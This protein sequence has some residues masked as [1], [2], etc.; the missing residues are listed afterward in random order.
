MIAAVAAKEGDII[1][2]VIV[3]CFVSWN[4]FFFLLLYSQLSRVVIVFVCKEG[5]NEKCEK[6][7]EEKKNE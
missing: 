6:M 2:H 1:I 4:F 7:R 5:N 3:C